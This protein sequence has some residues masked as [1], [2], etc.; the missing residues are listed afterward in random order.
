MYLRVRKFLSNNVLCL[1]ILLASFVI[2][3]SS[4]A[5]PNLTA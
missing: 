5:I 4:S 2:L 1:F 3:S